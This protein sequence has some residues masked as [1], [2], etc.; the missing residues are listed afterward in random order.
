MDKFPATGALVATPIRLIHISAQGS[1]PLR[2]LLC[3]FFVQVQRIAKFIRIREPP[4]G[5]HRRYILFCEQL[6]QCR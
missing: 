6:A 1:K 2:K 5:I 4:A 3:A